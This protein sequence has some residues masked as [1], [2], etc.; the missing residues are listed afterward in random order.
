NISGISNRFNGKTLVT[1]IRHQVN[2]NNWQTDIQFGLSANWFSQENN[3]V[4]DTPAAGLLPA[5][6]GLQIG[7]VDEY[8]DD[9]DNQFRVKVK[10]PSIEKDGIVWARLASIDAGGG[11]GIFFRP[12]KGDEVVLGFLNDDPRQAI[13]LG[14]MHSP[15][16]PLPK[17]LNLS[18]ENY[19]KGIV[20]KEL[21]QII[22]DDENKL[23]ELRTPNGNILNISDKQIYLKYKDENDENGNSMIINNDGLHIKS[24]NNIV[25]EGGNITIKGSKVD[26][27]DVK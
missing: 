25:I 7:I 11:R 17:A 27:V 23:I 24:K 5:I 13:I 6:N 10:I 22:F 20:T 14:A 18:S 15:K 26:V 9:P 4:I 2:E 16:N 3:D 12:E 19:K 1:G 21:L 8:Q